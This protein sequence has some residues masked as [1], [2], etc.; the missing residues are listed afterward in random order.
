[1]FALWIWFT[2]LFF[3][4]HQG[5][6]A[7]ASDDR[8]TSKK[9]NV[10]YIITDQQRFDALRRVQDELVDYS[11]V[12]KI[13]TPHLDALSKRG[14]F[15]RNAYSQCP[16]C[17]PARTTLRTGCTVERTGVQTN[18]S[19]KYEYN[20]ETAKNTTTA[21]LQ[22]KIKAL[23]GLDQVLVESHGYTSEY[24]GKWHIPRGLYYKRDAKTTNMEDQVVQFNHY[25]YIKEMPAFEYT[26]NV[27]RYRKTLK[28]FDSIG[29]I[30]LDFPSTDGDQLDKFSGYAYTPVHLDSRFGYP[31]NTPLQEAGDSN[32][33]RSQN[34]ILGR[35]HLPERF[36]DTSITADQ[37]IRA[38]DRL[39]TNT[40]PFLLTVSFHSPHP[41]FCAPSKYLDYYWNQREHLFVPP[42]FNDTLENSAY[43]TKKAMYSQQQGYSNPEYIQE[44]TALYYALVEEVDTKIGELLSALDRNNITDDTMIIFTSDHGEMLGAHGLRDK[45]VFLE[46]ATHIPLFIAYPGVIA[47]G[48]EVNEMVN[49]LDLFSTV[50]DYA[51][52][53]LDDTSDG[54]SLRRFVEQT[55]FN[56]EHDESVAVVEWDY[57]DVKN[58]DT[59]TKSVDTNSNF[60]VRKGNYKLMTHKLASSTKTDMMYDLSTDPYEVNNLLGRNGMSASDAVIGKAEHLRH[61]LIEWMER[62]DGDGY[63]SDPIYNANDNAGDV[64]EI[65]NRQSW[66]SSDFWV[67]D[68]NQLEFGPAVWDGA[69][70]CVRNEYFYFGRTNDGQVEIKDTYVDGDSGNFF[71]VEN[72][73]GTTLG[74]GDH[75]RLKVTLKVP[76]D[77]PVGIAAAGQL[78]IQTNLGDSRIFL[79]YRSDTACGG[80]T[81]APPSESPSENPSATLS[82][83]PTQGKIPLVRPVRDCSKENPCGRCQG[84]CRV[85]AECDD[86]LI[87]FY[88]DNG[89][90]GVDSV[91]GCLGT[92]LSRVDWCMEGT[93]ADDEPIPLVRP[94]TKYCTADEPC[95][96]CEGHCRSND[97]CEGDL[98]CF[99][100]DNGV[101]GIDSVPGC[102]GTDLS[103]ADWCTS[104]AA[105]AK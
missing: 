63:Y 21:L 91:P 43:L 42:S 10:L 73:A 55:S 93:R 17:G 77:H 5:V 68:S 26:P 29:E 92:D 97:D 11:N 56:E 44:Y 104:L 105:I 69:N 82:V 53:V 61:L 30:S 60:M 54:T 74:A 37:A 33:A 34:S 94:I 66:R 65:R 72:L 75:R 70:N 50:L 99:E 14:A 59:L 19:T 88:K 78:V 16:V 6:Q 36:S 76:E 46:E 2:L 96:R 20:D 38:M 15:F 40:S 28:H 98:V 3:V 32:Y 41:P 80:P 71:S 25:D 95:S 4:I 9:P 8:T 102:L 39:S 23:Q 58:D 84:H 27:Y 86:G 35:A 85:D 1:M 47:P 103:R 31:P 51:G 83:S 79:R 90:A 22:N 12:T 57:R 45:G 24:Y 101:P 52:A 64:L 67:S 89:V 81:L 87:C 62:M 13:R 18:K 49:H 48:Q 100:K 7:T